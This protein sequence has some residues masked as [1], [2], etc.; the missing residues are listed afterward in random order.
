VRLRLQTDTIPQTDYDDYNE[1]T[2][3]DDVRAQA[4]WTIEAAMVKS[5]ANDPLS[6]SN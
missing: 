6:L 3:Y 4:L 1:Y 2:D 5:S